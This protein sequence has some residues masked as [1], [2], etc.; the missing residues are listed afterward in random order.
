[1]MRL[2]I[3]AASENR[4]RDLIPSERALLVYESLVDRDSP[5]QIR[6]AERSMGTLS[7]GVKSAYRG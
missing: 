3:T 2:F 5:A 4:G 1:M 6:R 7:R